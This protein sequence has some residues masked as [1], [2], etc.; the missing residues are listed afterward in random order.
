MLLLKY[1]LSL[2]KKDPADAQIVS[3]KLML[4][5][6]MIRQQCAGIYSWLP[7]GL[8]VLQNI[9]AIVRENMNKAGGLEI[10]MP[11]IQPATLWIESGRFENYGKEMLK[12][13][14]RH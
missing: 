13:Q 12:F 3:H 1:F 10:L 8:K 9:E 2:L 6:G 11:C 5:S 4:R 14:D 7:L